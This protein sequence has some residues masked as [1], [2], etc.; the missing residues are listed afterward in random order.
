MLIGVSRSMA[1]GYTKWLVKWK[2][3]RV[4]QFSEWL[5]NGTPV[6]TS[7]PSM[8]VCLHLICSHLYYVSVWHISSYIYSASSTNF[9]YLLTS[10]NLKTS[11]KY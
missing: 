1:A 11:C 9:F 6:S 8:S 7:H 2:V 5:E 10:T 3:L 4:K